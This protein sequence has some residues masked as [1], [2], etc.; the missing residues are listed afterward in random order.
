[1]TYSES[2]RAGWLLMWRG[3]MIYVL[4]LGSASVLVGLA[5]RAFGTGKDPSGIVLM[6]LLVAIP[7]CAILII[8][9]WI[10]KMLIR[11]DFQ[12]FHL[13]IVRQEGNE[14]QQSLP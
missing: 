2:L 3:A 1:M 5:G 8:F 14:T 7:P 4:L 11:K 13:E 9:P 12:T 6:F 10:T